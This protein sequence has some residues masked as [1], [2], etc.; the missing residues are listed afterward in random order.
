MLRDIYV[1]LVDD[2]FIGK[3][4][5]VAGWIDSIRDHGGVL[6]IDLRDKEGKLQ[7][8]LEESENKHFYDIAK[9]FKEESVIAIE[10][11]VR[12]RPSGTENPKIKS[13]NVEIVIKNIELLN[14]SETLPFPIDDNVEIS[15]ELRL[16]YRYLDLRRNTMQKAIK[17]RS[18]ALKITR[19]FFYE[20]GFYEIETPF[21]I[22]STP[23]GARDFLVP[24]RLHPGK[25]YALPQS[26]QLFKQILMISGFDRYFQIAR[27]F[28]DEDLR[29][30]RQPEFTQID[31][32]MSF[33]EEEDVI[34]ISEKLLYKLF[35][36]LLDIELKTPF[37]RISYKEAMEKYG[38]DKP[39]T[40]FGL[41]LV[42]LTDIFKDTNFNVFKNAIEQKGIIKA[43]KINTI[44]SRK[45]ID[46]LT[47][48]VKG[49]GAKG[50]A[51]G[52][53]ENGEFNSPIAKFLTEQE[54]KAMLSRLEARNNEM[55]FFSAD[56]PKNVYKI[57]GNLRLQLGKM[58]KLIDY[59][60]F[61]LLWVVDFPMFEYNEEE[62]RLEAMHHPFTSPKEEDIETIRN[63]LDKNDKE[64]II[65]T[66]ES[67]TARAYDIVL[68]GVEIGGG[69]IR[70]HKPDVQ[71]LVFKLL[72]ISDEEADLKF[73]FLLEALKYGAPPHGGLAFGFDRL[74]AM[75]LGF[76]SIR[77][78]IA[79]PKTQKGACL[80]TGAPDV[81]PEKQL[82]ELHIKTV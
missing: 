35:L 11:V 56:K 4:I 57:L 65:N 82:K 20:N 14:A 27:C 21:L 19:D 46:N 15:E 63:I 7:A 77:D 8:V 32:E 68:N 81:V 42:D 43:I 37:K 24:S 61:E 73:G 3:K 70:I 2:S 80:L 47:E 62:G 59:S 5:K 45:E 71:K 54:V 17:T 38:S 72:N 33:V 51:W 48:Y 9:H 39:D 6:F 50:L 60:K 78:V 28:R 52:K 13:G 44:L 30:D 31:F 79:F 1:G 55:I 66:C 76:E 41:E 40:R 64:Y 53:V 69:S 34:N 25:F 36:E 18:K 49:L 58:L 22:K 67:I 23:E 75:M 10:G 16:K 29:S 12:R 74:I 26:P